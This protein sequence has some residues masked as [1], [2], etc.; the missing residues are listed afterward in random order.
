MSCYR[1]LCLEIFLDGE[2]RNV[3]YVVL[4]KSLLAQSGICRF[5]VAQRAEFLLFSGRGGAIVY[6]AM[7]RVLSGC[8]LLRS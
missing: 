6:Y 1:Y 8:F 2:V 5:A 7:H 4:V 3:V